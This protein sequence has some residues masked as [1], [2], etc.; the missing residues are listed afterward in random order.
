MIHRS[1]SLFRAK[2]RRRRELGIKSGRLWVQTA[3]GRSTPI[4]RQILARVEI[5]RRQGSIPQFLGSTR[6]PCSSDNFRGAF[7]RA[8]SD[9]R[10]CLIIDFSW[11]DDFKIVFFRFWEDDFESSF[12]G[13][14]SSSKNSKQEGLKRTSSGTRPDRVRT[15]KTPVV[16][17]VNPSCRCFA[18][19]V[20]KKDYSL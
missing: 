1:V 5:R 8:V 10:C 15:S 20:E 4:A 12:F 14:K 6:R 11:E 7:P 17:F 19:E 2:L 18:G 13:L 9:K 3:P 16:V